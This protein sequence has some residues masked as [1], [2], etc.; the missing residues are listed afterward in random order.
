MRNAFEFQEGRLTMT[1]ATSAWWVAAIL[2]ASV[3]PAA[4]AAPQAAAAPAPK[5][6]PKLDL[7]AASSG[8]EIYPRYCATCHGV[9]ARGNGPLAADLRVPVPDLTTIAARSG[10]KF[11]AERVQ[12]IITNGENLRGHGSADMPAWGDAFKRASGLDGATP[13]QAIRNLT[14]YLWSLQRDAG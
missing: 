7:S 11:P 12:K 10:G 14:H 8:G 5:Q 4:L 1:K 3:T 6:A 13:E 9:S 2:A